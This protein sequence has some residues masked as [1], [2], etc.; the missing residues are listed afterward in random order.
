MK[1]FIIIASLL[2]TGC[3]T[4]KK[5][6]K[7]FQSNPLK[8][9]ELCANAFP[10]KIEYREGKT[11]VLPGDTVVLKGDSVLVQADCPDGT[12]APVKCPPSEKEIIRILMLK[13][14]TL[15]DENHPKM[16]FLELKLRETEDRELIAKQTIE[17]L[18]AELSKWK[19]WFFILVAVVAVR[20]VWWLISFIKGFKILG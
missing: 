6:V 16:K 10:P 5:A 12:K 19:K 4:E 18:S 9:A 15:F 2:L 3:A 13:T 1:Y 17:S 20:V 11:I 8:L 14:D 7:F